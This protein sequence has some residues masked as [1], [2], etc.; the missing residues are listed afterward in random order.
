[1]RTCWSQIRLWTALSVLAALNIAAY[2]YSPVQN[3]EVIVN[4]IV[5][6]DANSNQRQDA[7][8]RG[9]ANVSVISQAPDAQGGAVNAST[10]T[11]ADGSFAIQTHVGDRLS[12]VPSAGYKALQPAGVIVR[13][14][15]QTLVF[16]LYVDKVVVDRIIR[17]EPAT[18]TMPAP[19]IF[20]SPLITIPAPVVNV[21]PADVRV[22][23]AEVIVQPA[24]VHVAP[25][26]EPAT[27]WAAVAVM[28]LSAFMGAAR[29]SAAI[30]AH[31]RTLRD[32]AIF[33]ARCSADQT[34][35]NA[36]NW[37]GIA[38]QVIADT[39][40]KVVTIESLVWMSAQPIPTMCFRATS[41]QVF[42]FSL[43]GKVKAH[44]FR[45]MQTSRMSSTKHFV[46]VIDLN[47]LWRYFAESMHLPSHL[48]SAKKWHVMVVSP[49]G[50]RNSQSF[51]FPDVEFSTDA[52]QASLS[53]IR[54]E[55]Q[56]AM[57][58][59]RANSEM[60]DCS[61]RAEQETPHETYLR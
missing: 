53:A 55:L 14:G 52:T 36:A 45:A 1:M 54:P 21:Q 19:Q 57:P 50:V 28:C 4:G 58:H 29:I 44:S 2:P 11:A 9:L 42:V 40:D 37:R 46:S 8:E 26:I 25:V 22:A 61:K 35:V 6:Y 10:V 47:A 5:F 18:V 17:M 3:G 51:D 34:K 33:Q 7:R 31:T 38:E 13:E 49:A 39:T 48:H 60:I 24:P 20:V 41:S 43:G 32:V 15:M 27:L 16:P 23:P 30:R 56:A 12:A 59:K